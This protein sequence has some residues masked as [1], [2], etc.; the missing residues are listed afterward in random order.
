VCGDKNCHLVTDWAIL[1]SYRNTAFESPNNYA[2][3]P[4]RRMLSQ[5]PLSAFLPE[6]WG[7]SLTD[8]PALSCGS[9]IN[10]LVDMTR[11]T[12]SVR[13]DSVNDSMRRFKGQIGTEPVTEQ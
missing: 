7:V 12:P 6:F 4:R 1:I 5:T 8:S 9:V 11:N 13:G 3:L 10:N 2:H